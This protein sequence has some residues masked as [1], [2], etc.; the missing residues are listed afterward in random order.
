[1]KKTT[2]LCCKVLFL[3]FSLCTS[4]LSAQTC[5]NVATF[6][7]E[8]LGVLAPYNGSPGYYND[9][10]SPQYVEEGCP[11]GT[12]SQGVRLRASVDGNLGDG[13]G[14]TETGGI[15]PNPTFTN[16]TKYHIA[17]KKLYSDFSAGTYSNI[18]MKIRLS[19]ETNNGFDC[20]APNCVTIVEKALML[21][22]GMCE[23]WDPPF[24]F[25]SPGDFDYMI[26]SIEALSD[27]GVNE[28]F[29]VIDDWCVEEVPE[30]ACIADLQFMQ[31]DCGKV[32]FTNLSTGGIDFLWNITDPNNEVTNSDEENPCLFFTIGGSYSVTLTIQCENGTLETSDEFFFEIVQDL[33]PF[34]E[35]CEQGQ[36]IIVE[37]QSI[38]G[39]CSFSE[40]SR[41]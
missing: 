25:V 15:N 34:F 32:Q 16:G 24:E 14:Y 26:I 19:N 27:A 31:E 28:L 22:P 9:Y 6:D 36:V 13:L 35:N 12:G 30:I 17:G 33:P 37:G 8:E 40:N 41:K 10:G 18:I 39:S 4:N 38:N 29:I 23:S 7:D 5:E 11:V 3:L 1:M 20:N 21:S 2:V